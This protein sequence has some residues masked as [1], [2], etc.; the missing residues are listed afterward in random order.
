[1]TLLHLRAS[2][3]HRKRFAGKTLSREYNDARG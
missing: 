2:A 3:Q 1:L